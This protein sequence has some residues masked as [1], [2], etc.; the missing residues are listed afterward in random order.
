MLLLYLPPPILAAHALPPQ[1]RLDLAFDCILHRLLDI[2]QTHGARTLSPERMVVGIRA[3]LLIAN[4]REYKQQAPP[5]PSL[6]EVLPSASDLRSKIVL[7]T[8]FLSSSASRDAGLASFL[9]PL[10]S[11]IARILATLDTAVGRPLNIM[12]Q[13]DPEVQALLKRDD[14]V[15][16][17][18]LYR[19]AIVAIPRFVDV[20]DFDALPLLFWAT[21]HLDVETRKLASVV[22]QCLLRNHRDLRAD[23]VRRYVAF[24]VTNVSFGSHAA[25]DHC[26]RV[27]VFLLRQWHRTVRQERNSEDHDY[28]AGANALRVFG[29]DVISSQVGLDRRGKRR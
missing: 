9:D 18:N 26:L 10:R 2:D 16:Q 25:L 8:Q 13:H 15:R 28:D 3:A 14:R 5:L 29:S 6:A 19:H 12:A 4:Q 1:E 20:K 27:V 7:S 23:I 11:C 24:V 21:V 17:L 22:L